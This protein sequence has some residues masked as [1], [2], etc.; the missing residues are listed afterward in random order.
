MMMDDDWNINI[1]LKIEL[2]LHFLKSLAGQ[3]FHGI[4]TTKAN[5]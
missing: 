2:F 4:V 1:L 5:I 3:P